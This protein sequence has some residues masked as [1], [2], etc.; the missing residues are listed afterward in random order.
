MSYRLNV[1]R[2]DDG[3]L[4]LNVNKVNLDNKY[5]AGNGVLVRNTNFSP[6]HFGWE[7]FVSMPFFHPPSIRPIS[8]RFSES[9]TYFSLGTMRASHAIE[10]KNFTKSS[11]PMA[12][13]RITAFSSGGL[14]AAL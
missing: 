6:N 9:C 1:W 2:N 13:A 3:E 11:S 12:R 7:F 8:S 14:Y 5:D 4:N 10:S